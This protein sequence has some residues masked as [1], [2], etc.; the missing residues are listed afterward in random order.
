[1]TINGAPCWMDLRSSDPARS[2]E[3]YGSLFGWAAHETGPQFNDYVNFSLDGVLAAGVVAGDPAGGL[4]DAWTTYFATTDAGATA[5]AI[6]AAGGQVPFGPHPVADQGL[7]AVAVDT[8]GA[9]FGL[10]QDAGGGREFAQVRPGAASYHEL[11]T[12]AYDQAVAFYAGV[13]GREAKVVGDSDDFRYSQLL[14]DD[15]SP[16][17]GIMQQA[18]VGAG[19]PAWFCYFGSADVDATVERVEELGGAVLEPAMDT[20]Y[21]RLATAADPTGAVFKLTSLP[22]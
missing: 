7:M 22:A 3:F 1:M 14:A 17:A 6:V 4:P 13:F 21:G 12:N 2:Q 18:R 20:P 19:A 15:G 8:G 5:R 9:P 16:V 10:W 11:H